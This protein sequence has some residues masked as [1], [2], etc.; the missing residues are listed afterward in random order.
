MSDADDVIRAAGDWL[1]HGERICIATI[2]RK[3]GSGPREVGA[4]MVISSSGRTAGTVGGGAVE[5]RIVEKAADVIKSGKPLMLDFDLSGEGTDLDAMCG[6]NIS[7]FLEPLGK[8][9]RLCVIGAGHVGKAVTRAAYEVGFAVTLVDD[10]QAHLAGDD[11]P[12]SVRTKVA[13]PEDAAGLGLDDSWFVVVCTRGHALD[14]EWLGEVLK[15]GPRYVGMLGSRNKA[16]MVFDA[17][18]KEGL[19]R[20]VLE[21]VHVPVGVDIRAVTPEEIAVSIVGELISEWRR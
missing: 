5:Q 4:K 11:L 18:E 16:R 21:Q 20:P 6:G 3:E 10:R 13:G 14:K 7:I 2:V 15:A 17:L 1:A 12:A 9:R 19:T 8:A